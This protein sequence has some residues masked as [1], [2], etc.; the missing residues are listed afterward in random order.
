MDRCY[1]SIAASE[2]DGARTPQNA[3]N[4]GLEE[5]GLEENGPKGNGPNAKKPAGK[6]LPAKTAKEN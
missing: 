4:E 5:N 1:R 2:K 3:G 6:T